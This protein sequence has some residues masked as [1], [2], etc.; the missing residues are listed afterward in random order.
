MGANGYGFLSLLIANASLFNLISSFGIESGITYHIATGK[1]SLNRVVSV[2]IIF[3]IIQIFMLFIIQL[4][5]SQSSKKTLFL[6]EHIPFAFGFIIVFIISL[7]LIDKF[8]AVYNGNRLFKLFNQVILYSNALILGLFTIIYFFFPA[9]NPGLYIQVY[10][11]SYFFQ[12]VIL[13]FFY[14]SNNTSILRPQTQ[15]TGGRNFFNYSMMA[16]VTNVIQFLAYRIDYWF[17]NYYYGEEHLGW[18]ALS[19]R[20]AQLFWIMPLLFGGVLLPVIAFDNFTEIKTKIRILIRMLNYCNLILGLFFFLAGNWFIPFVF[21]VEY[22]NSITPLKILL[23][24]VILFSMATILAAYFAGVNKLKVNF[25]GSLIC[26]TLI[27]I[28]DLLFIPRYGQIGAAIASGIGYG[29]TAFYFLIV[30][31]KTTQ[32]PLSSFFSFSLSDFQTVVTLI[33]SSF[34]K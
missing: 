14:Y 31:T 3:L 13:V 15:I 25:Y 18:Y 10:V 7:S 23:P 2:I 24:G 22:Y 11:A 34:K 30:F 21:G 5:L 29:V 8:T 6:E 26:F 16:F 32:L 20:L 4:I 1:Y 9:N 12:A 33:N 27:L 19:V 17:I 28:L